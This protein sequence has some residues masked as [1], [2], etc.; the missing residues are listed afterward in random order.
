MCARPGDSTS[1]FEDPEP[2]RKFPWQAQTAANNSNAKLQETPQ[3][4]STTAKTTPINQKSK[5]IHKKEKKRPRKHLG[6]KDSKDKWRDEQRRKQPAGGDAL[7]LSKEFKRKKE[8]EI[9]EGKNTIMF[10]Q[11]R[12]EK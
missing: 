8:Q 3:K 7:K 11:R 12:K 10:G 9:L 5:G 4:K 6:T 2:N 1:E